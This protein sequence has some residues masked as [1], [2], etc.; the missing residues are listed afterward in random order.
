MVAGR[1]VVVDGIETGYVGGARWLSPYR[2]IRT[3]VFIS[4]VCHL[5]CVPHSTTM[6]VDIE[7]FFPIVQIRGA[8]LHNEKYV[9]RLMRD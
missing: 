2:G 8:W 3:I 7:P 6:S 5:G 4:S 1:F 9:G